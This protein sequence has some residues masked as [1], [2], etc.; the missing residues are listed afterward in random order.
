[1]IGKKV[2]LCFLVF[3]LPQGKFNEIWPNCPLRDDF[4]S[5]NRLDKDIFHKKNV[6]FIQH[7]LAPIVK[8]IEAMKDYGKF[9]PD[10][11]WFVDIGANN[12]E[13]ENKQECDDTAIHGEASECLTC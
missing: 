4:I 3:P 10:N 13:T 11:C 2:K 12:G 6:L 7:C 5:E 1:M 9:D 8:R